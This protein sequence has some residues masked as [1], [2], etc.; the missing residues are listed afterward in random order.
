M[1]PLH[2]DQQTR[3]FPFV[4]IL[5]IALNVAVFA[6][7]QLCV[8]LPQSVALAAM[9]PAEFTQSP[10]PQA[11][12][13]MIASMF[14]HGSWMH[15]I[16]NMWFMWIFGNNIEDATGHARFTV[17]YFVC[18]I[19]A[20]FA[21]IFAT[22]NSVTPMIGAS[23]AVSGILGAYLML[24]PNARI[25]TFIPLGIFFRVL[26]LPAYVF[27]LIWIG[28]QILSQMAS[29][30]ASHRHGGG[31]AYLAHIGGFCAGLFLI[32]FFKEER[33]SRR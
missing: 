20:D 5:I 18:G 19:L 24:H 10:S 11:V 15:L 30:V 4:T 14:M 31:V 22:P 3:R 8:G 21:H 29:G 25:S 32:F 9:V 12:A 1:L 13:H 2:D 23:G 17:F 7:W 33:R 6:G 16:G 27:L 26:E 28:F